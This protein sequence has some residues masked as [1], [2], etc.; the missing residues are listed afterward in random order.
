[1]NDTNLIAQLPAVA[2]QAQIT[3]NTIVAAVS[4]VVVL[5]GTLGR[6]Y[7]AL[8]TGNSITGALVTGTNT[9]AME[10]PAPARSGIIVKGTSI[11]LALGLASALVVSYGCASA[12]KV[13]LQTVG[14]TKIAAQTALG[15]WNVWVGSGKATVAQELQVRAAFLK[16]QTAMLAACDA[17]AIWAAAS[18]TNSAGATGLSAAYSA[19]ITNAA[20]AES[21]VKTLIK[22]FGVKF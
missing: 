5:V 22:S 12:N 4:A 1:M 15:A 18:S 10:P 2:A 3:M 21:D 8:K 20:Q 6:V 17:G 19:A 13:A 9:P 7:H 16:W 14:T 11:L